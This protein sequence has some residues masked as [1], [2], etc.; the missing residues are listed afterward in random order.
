LKYSIDHARES[1]ARLI[2]VLYLYSVKGYQK[3]I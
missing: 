3:K 1:K 2:S